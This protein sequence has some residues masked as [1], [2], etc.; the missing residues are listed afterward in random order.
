ME[1]I[2]PDTSSVL[3][4]VRRLT[5]KMQPPSMMRW[6]V[7]RMASTPKY[8]ADNAKKAMPP[9]PAT[10]PK[11]STFRS[12]TA[13]LTL[14]RAQPGAT[15]CSWE[16]VLYSCCWRNHS[17]ICPDNHDVVMVFSTETNLGVLLLLPPL[18]SLL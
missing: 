7:V 5:K 8:S 9:M 14:S 6:I 4:L 1:V 11:T 12:R 18:A 10:P 15:S 3:T 16:G 17:Q 13:F 2:Q